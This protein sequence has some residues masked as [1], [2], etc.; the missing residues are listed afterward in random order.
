MYLLITDSDKGNKFNA[1]SS[2]QISIPNTRAGADKT[3]SY[4][5][6]TTKQHPLQP[7]SNPNTRTR[8]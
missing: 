8:T 3:Y 1:V 2:T 7:D 5:N 4:K 6:P